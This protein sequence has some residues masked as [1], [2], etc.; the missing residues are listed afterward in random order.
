MK[1]LYISLASPYYIAQEDTDKFNI[2]FKEL[3][4]KISE[5]MLED[6]RPIDKSPILEFDDSRT[7]N[8]GYGMYGKIH[9]RRAVEKLMSLM[10]IP[11]LSILRPSIQLISIDVDNT[12]EPK[13]KFAI[14]FN[15]HSNKFRLDCKLQ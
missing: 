15:W 9:A 13:T 12:G 7:Y 8:Y 11:V 2:L 5:H 14:K 4:S 3:Y 1:Q 10:D 6:I